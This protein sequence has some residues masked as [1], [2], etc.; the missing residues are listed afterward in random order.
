MQGPIVIASLVMATLMMPLLMAYWFAPAL[1]A[2]DDLTA[3]S[4]M[5]LSFFGCMKNVLSFLVY[6]ILGLVLLLIGVIPLGLGLLVVLPV[7]TA[8]IYVAYRDI[9]YG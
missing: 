3:F 4:A 5:K 1:V 7:L 2:L 8:S 9:Y 6:G